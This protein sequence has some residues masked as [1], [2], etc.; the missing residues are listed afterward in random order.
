MMTPYLNGQQTT[1]AQDADFTSGG[2]EVVAYDR[3]D[4]TPGVE[5]AFNNF[6]VSGS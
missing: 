4:E 5:V 6:A 1:R 2:I 3:A